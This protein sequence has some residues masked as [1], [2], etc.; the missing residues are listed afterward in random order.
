MDGWMDGWIDGWMDGLMD[1]WIDGWMD[2][3]MIDW[4]IDWLVGWLVGWFDW[5]V[6]LID[7]LVDWWIDW[8]MDGWIDW[9]IWLIC[10]IDWLVPFQAFL[11]MLLKSHER[12]AE[13]MASSKAGHTGMI[14][15]H[16]IQPQEMRP[17]SW[18]IL[19]YDGCISLERFRIPFLKGIW[20]RFRLLLRYNLSSKSEVEFHCWFFE[21]SIF[22]ERP[23][24][25][26]SK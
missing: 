6:W 26:K 2:G 25:C 23:G 4:L 5:F 13:K 7:W 15:A 11:R 17:Q 19:P 1:G 12:V 10:L 22:W 3:W 18:K 14:F 16:K 24:C 9:L 21:W 20:P 8:W